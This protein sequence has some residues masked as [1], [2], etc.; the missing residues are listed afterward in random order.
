MKIKINKWNGFGVWRWN[1]EEDLCG[2]CRVE[3]HYPCPCCNFPDPDQSNI[4]LGICSHVFHAHCIEK[5]MEK[6]QHEKKCPMCRQDWVSACLN[7]N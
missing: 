3:L 7:K 5:W 4:L 1:M 6:S 2:I